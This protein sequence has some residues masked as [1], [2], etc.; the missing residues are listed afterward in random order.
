MRSLLSGRGRG[1]GGALRPGEVLAA[2][3]ALLGCFGTGGFPPPLS[4]ERPGAE[5]E[6][7]A[8][9]LYERGVDAVGDRRYEAA[10]VAFDSVV[11]LYP[12]SNTSTVSLRERG[13]AA[14][15]LGRHARAVEDLRRL[16]DEAPGYET[17]DT[18]IVLA[19]AYQ[20]SRDPE[21]ALR[22]LARRLSER[23]ASAQ[24]ARIVAEAA[25]RDLA[26]GSASLLAETFPE[27]PFLLSLY[28]RAADET[29]L[30]DPARAAAFTRIAERLGG[31]G[32]ATRPAREPRD[33]PAAGGGKAIGAI[34]PRTG[35]LAGVAQDIED[36]IRLA[37][38]EIEASGGPAFRLD[39]LPEGGVA[40]AQ[41]VAEL[42][43]RGVDVV[44]GPLESEAAVN[45][46][47]AALNRG[48]LL[49]TPTAT[50]STLLRSGAG[51]VAPNAAGGEA[52][53]AMGLFAARNLRLLRVAILGS[54]DERG[55]VDARAFR[56][57]FEAEGGRV[58][59]ER[60]FSRGATNFGAA[61]RLSRREGAQALFLPTRSADQ[62]LTVLSQIEYYSGGSFRLLGTEVWRDA[63]F[64]QRA[65]GFAEGAWFVDTFSPDP[66][67]TR[68]WDFRNAY[69][70]RYGRSLASNFPAWGYD[71][72]MLALRHLPRRSGRPDDERPGRAATSGG[73]AAT[74]SATE[75]TYVGA[76]ATYR[77]RGATVSKV[78]VISRIA[79]GSP[80]LEGLGGRAR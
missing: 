68:H 22:T 55:R 64:L 67:V 5:G 29:R 33:K 42:A 1:S 70:R 28:A 80:V 37:L 62:V 40:A 59:Q 47:G 48:V 38:E 34:L 36:G 60:F 46:A 69:F 19:S 30:E 44:I 71:A 2:L 25:V 14:Y 20:R 77:I 54:D 50:D 24:G 57:A 78:P 10:Y 41:S 61:L 65:G 39:V 49:V 72:A 15:R 58:V 53:E 75:T 17:T 27:R 8:R 26:P 79:S 6:R 18:A 3:L 13:L 21:A 66:A 74:E 63:G 76:G 73:R 52:G 7:A 43:G 51:V 23:D 12:G 11:S 31:R 32:A 4:G 16:L 56:R 9:A 35:R 45:A